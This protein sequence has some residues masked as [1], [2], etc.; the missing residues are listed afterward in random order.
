MLH[1][2]ITVS[3]LDDATTWFAQA[4]SAQPGAIESVAADTARW[5]RPVPATRVRTLSLGREQV[6]LVD[7]DGPALPGGAHVSNTAAFQH[8]ALVV[9]DIDARWHA[10]AAS[11]DPISSVPQRIPDSN[12]VA[13]GIRAAYFRG[14]D[15][16]ALEL[17]HYPDDKGA[18]RWHVGGDRVLGIDHT[19]I[20]VA[21]TER[22]LG[23]WRDLLG[24][25]VVGES[26]NEGREQAQLSGVDGAR[27]HITALRGA[28]G[29]GVELLEYLEPGLVPADA[30]AH[31]EASAHAHT[32]V[33][34]ADLDATVAAVRDAE[35]T[36]D[37]AVISA[38]SSECIAC[39]DR[40][41]AIM[42]RDPDGHVVQLVE[43]RP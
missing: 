41:R 12:R 23:F 24:L 20:A 42:V 43:A 4:L 26:L 28:G 2:A 16:H 39:G 5:G 25:E 6:V 9:G 19:A 35:A 8:L 36:L 27:V 22:S 38:R 31:P 40:R 18:S 32:T 17:I 7:P 37:V 15:A 13:A 10:I 11:I 29:L 33:R 30:I 34:V 14:P 3:S 1:V 21:Q